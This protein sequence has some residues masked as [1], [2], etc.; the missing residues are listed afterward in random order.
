MPPY[1]KPRRDIL[2]KLLKSLVYG[3]EISLSVL[4]T[5]DMVNKA[6][7][8]HGFSPVCAAAFGRTI[9]ACTFMSSGLKNEGD[10]LSVTVK[11]DGPCGKITVCGN[12]KLFMRG[13]M[14]N[15]QVE[16]PLKPNGKLD[17]SGAVG[18]NGRITVVKS[19]GLKEQYSGSAAL[20]SGEIAED[21]T[22]YYAL[23]EQ[24]PTAMA[25]GVKIGKTRKCVGAGGVIVQTMP[26]ASAESVGEA[27]AVMKN[28]SNVSTLIEELG[29]EGI[30][31]KYFADAV[32]DV[33]YPEYKC[34]CSRNYL[35][36]IIVSLGKTEVEDIINKQGNI[37]VKCEFCG[38]KYV[39]TPE[40]VE[41]LFKD[42]K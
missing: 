33:Y 40:D 26:G 30:M 35:K 19:M 34:L 8:V 10:K 7:K 15:G 16:L 21:F 3:G 25:L 24:Q 13:Y 32:Y 14:D 39:F 23:S 6:I 38:K 22:S 29:A 4:E 27:E 2:N 12:G 20:V 18:K 31:K 28:F 5:T 37:E 11:G 1:R 17:V 36:K 41:K 42:G 9:T